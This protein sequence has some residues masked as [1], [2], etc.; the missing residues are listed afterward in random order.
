MCIADNSGER[1]GST[2]KYQ[3][4]SQRMNLVHALERVLFLYIAWHTFYVML[5]YVVVPTM[6]DSA[7]KGV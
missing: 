6:N 2:W 4:R 3:S 7:Q 1:A 5:S